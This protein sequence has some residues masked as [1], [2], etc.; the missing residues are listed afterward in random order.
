SPEE[1]LAELY[2][3]AYYDGPPMFVYTDGSCLDN[4]TP[5]ARAGAGVYWGPGAAK[6]LSAR[7]PGLQTNGRGELLAVVFALLDAELCR[8]LVICSDSEYVIHS[9]CHWAPKREATG[10]DCANS[11]MLQ[12]A[13]RLLQLR[14]APTVFRW[15]KAHSGNQHNDAADSLAKAG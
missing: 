10:W 3:P 14:P 5:S 7:V 15:V 6:N 12:D 4:G 9:L 11:D 8:P 13:V 2:G 1:A